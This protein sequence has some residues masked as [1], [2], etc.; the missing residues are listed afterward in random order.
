VK[1]KVLVILLCALIILFTVACSPDVTKFGSV[2]SPPIGVPVYMEEIP[3][4]TLPRGSLVERIDLSQMGRI[5]RLY[6]TGQLTIFFG[7]ASTPTPFAEEGY[8]SARLDA[9]QQ[10]AQFISVRVQSV[11]S[12]LSTTIG[13]LVDDPIVRSEVWSTT[14]TVLNRVQRL[15]TDVKIYGGREIVWYRYHRAGELPRYGVVILYDPYEAF[16]A[17]MNHPDFRTIFEETK[18]KLSEEL[19]RELETSVEES[20]GL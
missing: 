2:F 19:S 17:L 6:S 15:F 1:N 12:K 18:R 9:L 7:T 11:E 14:R 16:I 20:L 10:M 5:R 4:V 8:A 3:L 13:R